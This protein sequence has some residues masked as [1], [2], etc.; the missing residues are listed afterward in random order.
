[1]LN[2]KCSLLNNKC[3]YDAT[4]NVNKTAFYEQQEQGRRSEE[5]EDRTTLH[6]EIPA[7]RAFIWVQLV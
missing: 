4:S 2:A 1:M 3:F 6:S 5:R 7:L